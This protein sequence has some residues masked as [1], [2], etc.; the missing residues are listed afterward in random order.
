V[1][2]ACDWVVEVGPG[3]AAAGGRIVSEGP[4][5]AEAVG[6]KKAAVRAA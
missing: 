2:A 4:P 3:A 5:T 6:A 1:I